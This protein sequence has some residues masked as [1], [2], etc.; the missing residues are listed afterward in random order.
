MRRT[1]MLA[2]AVLGASLI[3]AGPALADPKHCPPGHAKKGWCDGRGVPGWVRDRDDDRWEDRRERWEDRWDDRRDRWED[4]RAEERAYEQGYRDAMRHAYRVGQRLPSDRYRVVPD[5]YEYG[6][7]A[8]GQGR[9][10]VVADQQHYLINLAT[11][12][13]LDVLSR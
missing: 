8:P 7:P 1:G 4:R 11:G 12:L 13:I 2:A 10:Y 6:W 9:G 5:Y 3:A